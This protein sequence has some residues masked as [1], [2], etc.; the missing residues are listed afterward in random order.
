MPQVLY[1]VRN[2]TMPVTKNDLVEFQRFAEAQVATGGVE[3]LPELFDIW[4][5]EHPSA[6][7]HDQNVAAIR[8]AVHDMQAGDLGRPA[9]EVLDELRREFALPSNQ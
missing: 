6:E 8:A 1:V 7:L 5:S 9:T 3:S 2:E 4:E